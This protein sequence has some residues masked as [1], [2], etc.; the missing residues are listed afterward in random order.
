MYGIVLPQVIGMVA[1]EATVG[2]G[3]PL[4]EELCGGGIPPGEE[5]TQGA[6][7]GPGLGDGLR[8][9][10]ARHLHNGARRAQRVLV[11]EDLGVVEG[12]GRDGTGC[13]LIVTGTGPETLEA[14]G[15][16]APSQRASVGTLTVWRVE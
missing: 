3:S 12:L 11:L 13:A 7:R 8:S 9:I 15:T 4:V 14:M 10:H 5:A 6:R 16:I 2:L 1:L